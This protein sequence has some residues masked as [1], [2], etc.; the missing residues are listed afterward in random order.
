MA[1]VHGS[2]LYAL[3]GR[4]V[5]SMTGLCYVI[6]GAWCC[7]APL[8]IDFGGPRLELAFDGFDEMHLG[9]ETIDVDEPLDT[10]DQ[11]DPE[12]ALAWGDPQEP[13]LAGILGAVV[14]EVRV[15]E[16]DFRLD[17][18]D[19]QRLQAWLLAGLELVFDDGRAVQLS[20][21]FSEL[22]VAAE[23]ADDDTWRRQVVRS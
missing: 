11:D 19:G 7:T 12:L 4:R 10:P 17:R 20:N 1:R 15:L 6:D 3:V 2:R 5:R 14:R 23:P 16:H 18:V 9:W 21:V 8:I 13:H 22:T